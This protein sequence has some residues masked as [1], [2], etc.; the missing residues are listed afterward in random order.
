MGPGFQGLLAVVDNEGGGLTWA[1]GFGPPTRS[2][3]LRRVQEA[4]A[5][6]LFRLT[7]HLS[8]LPPG[9]SERVRFGDEW[10]QQL[11]DTGCR[12]V[13][14]EEQGDGDFRLTSTCEGSTHKI[15]P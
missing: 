12:V 2:D 10:V 13:T 11:I 15:V 6:D 3:L 5:G 7:E 1:A 8:G 4:V 14:A 9:S